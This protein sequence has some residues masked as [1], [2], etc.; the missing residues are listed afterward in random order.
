MIL[1]LFFSV[2]PGNHYFVTYGNSFF[3]N[4]PLQKGQ[5]EKKSKRTK[6]EPMY[7][8]RVRSFVKNTGGA[9]RGTRR[10]SLA[11]YRTNTS[12]IDRQLKQG[13]DNLLKRKLP[14]ANEYPQSTNSAALGDVFRHVQRKRLKSQSHDI[15]IRSFDAQQYRL[16]CH[17]E[18]S[19]V[20]LVNR[21]LK[22]KCEVYHIDADRCTRCDRILIFDPICHINICVTCHKIS[23]T[24]MVVEDTNNDVLA[25]KTQVSAPT[26]VV[27]PPDNR[28]SD[29]VTGCHKARIEAYKQYLSQ[30]ASDLPPIKLATL[31]I[32][33]RALSSVHIFTSARCRVT[34]I[35]SILKTHNLQSEV[36]QATRICRF[37]NGDVIPA[38]TPESTQRLIERYSIWR[39]FLDQQKVPSFEDLTHIALRLENDIG[40]AGLFDLHKSKAIICRIQSNLNQI[41]DKC[42]HVKSEW[43]WEVP[44]LC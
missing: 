19:T 12:V 28:P 33:Y 25:F 9:S 7:Q 44:D 10:L 21:L 16:Q 40:T 17:N 27:V 14:D 36:F 5:R 13:R 20:I 11:E 41:A 18:L 37:F 23:S 4:L 3:F 24:L 43:T 34:T 22:V 31:N 35:I 1:N 32:I 6:K 8:H 39:E 30:F 2:F 26:T 29:K 15:T 38:L 42:R